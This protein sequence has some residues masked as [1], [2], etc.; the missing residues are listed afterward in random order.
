LAKTKVVSISLLGAS[1][2]VVTNTQRFEFIQNE[3]VSER[4]L[5]RSLVVS[6]RDGDQSISDGQTVTCLASTILSGSRQLPWPV[7]VEKW[8][9]FL[10]SV[11]FDNCLLRFQ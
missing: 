4:I 5:P 10:S 9:T 3:A 7:L 8:A 2:K 11:F 6:L 1:N